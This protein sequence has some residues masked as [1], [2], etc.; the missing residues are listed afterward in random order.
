MLKDANDSMKIRSRVKDDRVSLTDLTRN[1]FVPRKTTHG[2]RVDETADN[3]LAASSDSSFPISLLI[4]SSEYWPDMR[5][6]K[7]NVPEPIKEAMEQC[8]RIFERTSGDRT[9]EWRHDLG[10]VSMTLEIAGRQLSI[11]CSAY[12]AC[13]LWYFA[14]ESQWE[15]AD[16][17][18]AM[19]TLPS[20]LRRKM[21]YWVN[22]D[23]VRRVSD[24]VFRV[25]SSLH[26]VPQGGTASRAWAGAAAANQVTVMMDE[27]EVESAVRSREETSQE[28]YLAQVQFFWRYIQSMLTNLK[29]LSLERMYSMLKMFV[30]RSQSSREITREQLKGFL[31]T[32]VAQNELT[33]GASGYSLVRKK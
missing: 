20:M 13:I 9:I 26:A 30:T 33:V 31:D 10:Q 2:E 4:M 8:R 1:L 28:E 19:G 29:A 21:Q 15:I 3:S 18:A 5:E 25:C 11:T 7:L 6:E 22:R 23:I 32:K 17:A 16:M 24:D 12:H 27:E 14:Q